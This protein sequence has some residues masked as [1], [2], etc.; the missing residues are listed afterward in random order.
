MRITALELT[1]RNLP[2]LHEFYGTT[3][4]L[5][6]VASD[7]QRLTMQAG[8]TALSFVPAP[9]DSPHPYHFAFNIPENRLSAAK[10]WLSTRTPLL[11][12]S[13]GS[14]EFDFA[15]WHAHSVYFNDPAGNLESSPGTTCPT[16]QANRSGPIPSSQSAR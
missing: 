14:D 6:V 10:E 2:S 1:A 12:N 3:L 16:P 15:N 11:K 7:N 4:G 13:S 9:D 8:T 5:A